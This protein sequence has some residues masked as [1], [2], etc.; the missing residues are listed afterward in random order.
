MT[1]GAARII[2]LPR[3]LWRRAR[4]EWLNLSDRLTDRSYDVETGIPGFTLE[5]RMLD[6]RN[7]GNEGISYRSLGLIADRISPRADDVFYD[8]GCGHGRAVLFFART[9]IAR[10]VGVELRDEVIARARENAARLKGRRCEIDLRHG[11]ALTQ[12]YSDASF[13]YLYNPFDGEVMDG[14]LAK[15][16]SDRAGRPTRFVYANPTAQ[17]SFEQAGW[18]SLADTF[19]VPYQ[20]TR[21]PVTVWHSNEADRD[22][23][24]A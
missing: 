17:T 23:A 24:P 19:W 15:I 7:H 8:I 21:M 16:R 4:K 9:P 1:G 18:L 13:I 3:K 14:V 11:D 22:Q 2:Q 10:A 12:D 20:G 6:E 5:S